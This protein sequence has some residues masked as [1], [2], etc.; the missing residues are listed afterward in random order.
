MTGYLAIFF[1]LIALIAPI[2][3]FK[4]GH[5]IGI[6][7]GVDRGWQEALTFVVH[8]ESETEK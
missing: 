1:A 5:Y 7:D 8:S 4:L 3:T 2:L 6:N